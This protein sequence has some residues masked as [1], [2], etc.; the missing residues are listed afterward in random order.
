MFICP[1]IFMMLSAFDPSFLP[2]F[3]CGLICE[4]DKFPGIGFM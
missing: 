2:V 1:T 3:H 4:L